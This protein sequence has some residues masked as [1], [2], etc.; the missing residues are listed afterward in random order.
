M[1]QVILEP[2]PQLIPSSA[3]AP[4]LALAAAT[5]IGPET[6]HTLMTDEERATRK[7]RAVDTVMA[8]WL[9]IAQRIAAG[10]TGL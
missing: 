5:L 10:T 7:V 9:E 2:Q 3:D 4:T 1:T 6:Y 8:I